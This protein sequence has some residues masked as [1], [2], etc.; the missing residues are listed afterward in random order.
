MRNEDNERD[1]PT[2]GN[3][4]LPARVFYGLIVAG[5]LLGIG[6]CGSA[7]WAYLEEG[8]REPTGRRIWGDVAK[9]FVIPIA[10]MVGSTFG[11]LVGFAVAVICDWRT[12]KPK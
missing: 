2:T 12:A 5:V 7:A 3:T 9:D 8:D 1:G 6:V 10:V 4:R 11:G